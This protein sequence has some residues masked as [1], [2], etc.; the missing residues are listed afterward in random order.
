M[1]FFIIHCYGRQDS[2]GTTL[3]CL[4]L[5]H[6]QSHGDTKIVLAHYMIFALKGAPRTQGPEA[7]GAV[8]VSVICMA[9]CAYA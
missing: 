3:Q 2:N 6:T 9:G 4:S 7:L 8:R 5:C 1:L